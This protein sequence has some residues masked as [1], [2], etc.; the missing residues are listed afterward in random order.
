MDNHLFFATAPLGLELLL[1]DELRG[2]SLADVKDARAGAAFS[3]NLE[4][5]YRACLWSRLA[6]RILLRLAT[7]PAPTPE[8]LYAGALA[9]DWAE[10]L[11]PDSTIAVD[12]AASRSQITH[13]QYGAQK[14]KD[15]I[16]DQF[17][18]LCGVRPSVRLDRPDIRVNVYLDKDIAQVSLDLSGDSL[19]KRGYRLDGG[20]APLK[21]NLA[22]AILLRAGWPQVAQAGGELV[23]PM[24]GS[25]TLLVEAAWMAA[26][27]APGLRRDFYGFQG[28]KNHRADIWDALVSEAQARREAGLRREANPISG[29]DLDRHAV[30]AALDN[31]DRAG[32]RGRVQVSRREAEEAR[33]RL[34]HGLLV[35]N[36]P[37]GERMGEAEQLAGL[38]G[39]LGKLLQNHFQGWKA[40]VFT[41]NPD[42]AFKLGIR[43][44]KFYTL[45]NGAIECKLFNFDVEPERY[46][47]PHADETGLSEEARKSRQLM[48]RA[49]SLAQRPETSPGAEMFANRLRKNLKHLS[50]WARQ[51]GVACYRLYDADL[52]EYA[53]AVDVYH[54]EQTWLHVQEYEAPTSIDPEKAEARLAEA[55]SVMPQVLDI[56]E[57]QVY[58][59]IRRRQKGSAQYEKQAEAGQFHIVEEGGCKFWVNFEDYLDTG[60]FLDHR[61]TRLMI[62]KL[63]KDKHF[64]NLFAYT[65]A[66]TVHAAVGGARSSVS[67]DMS[68]TYIDWA[69]RNLELNGIKGYQHGLVQ[70]DCLAWLD[71]ELG[72]G[73]GGFD[74][75]FVDPPT[76][77]NSKRM[78]STFDVQRDHVALLRKAAELLNPSGLLIF[79]TNFRKFKLD[80]EALAGLSVEDMSAKTVPTD[81]ERNPKIHYCWAIRP[82]V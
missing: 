23:D 57:Q 6:N 42:L 15:A 58:L 70:G 18:E 52:P 44:R 2:L 61:P 41:G 43:A 39:G 22:A 82:T 76:F 66:A 75:I 64:L 4:A 77:S 69:R 62:Q 25:G 59:K 71:A 26:D 32:L 67:V 31:I 30:H 38:Y 40:S 28:W 45:Y 73:R 80:R 3:G 47:T 78:D 48:R 9:I 19:H 46:F 17:R 21:E 56:P 33:P 5:A 36:P 8:A 51:N 16:V 27:V 35:V 54:G 74:L 29:Y 53:V 14:V 81:F 20:T 12:F 24:C 50:R 34:A 72:R 11:S 7:F 68:H 65:G 13:T 79:S 55:L 60:L 1:A 63:A 37:Y 49:H 10:H